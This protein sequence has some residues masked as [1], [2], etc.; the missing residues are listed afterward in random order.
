MCIYTHHV[1]LSDTHLLHLPSP[2]NS[3]NEHRRPLLA[4]SPISF[5]EPPR[6][7]KQKNTHPT[8]EYVFFISLANIYLFGYH[9]V[10][11]YY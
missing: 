4:L 5:A 2:H 6:P 8:V 3:A 11:E 1:S 9:I 7:H 10:K